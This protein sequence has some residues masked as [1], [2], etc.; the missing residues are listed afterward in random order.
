MSAHY[1][2]VRIVRNTDGPWPYSAHGYDADEPDG[3]LI[4]INSADGDTP[5]EAR[6]ELL[7]ERKPR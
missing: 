3:E 1:D 2:S 6:R 5:E 4:W 7:A